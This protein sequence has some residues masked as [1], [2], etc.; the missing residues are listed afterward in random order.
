MKQ[1]MYSNGNMRVDNYY[2]SSSPY[3]REP[4]GPEPSH[5]HQQDT[6]LLEVCHFLGPGD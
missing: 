1:K 2:L 3:P 6:S 5:S 4:S